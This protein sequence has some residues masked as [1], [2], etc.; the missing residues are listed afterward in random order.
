MIITTA[1]LLHSSGDAAQR[2]IRHD[3]AGEQEQFLIQAAMSVELAG[4]ALLVSL[5]PALVIDAKF[6]DSLLHACGAGEHAKAGAES[7]RRISASEVVNRCIQVDVRLSFLKDDLTLLAALRNSVIHLGTIGERRE[8]KLL[9]T[10][11]KAV[12]MLAAS[13]GENFEN[14]FADYAE[15]AAAH[16]SQSRKQVELEVL[17]RVARGRDE[18]ERRFGTRRGGSL[19]SR[20]AAIK[21]GSPT[22]ARG[23]TGRHR[24]LS[25]SIRLLPAL[26][27]TGNNNHRW[28]GDKATPHQNGFGTAASVVRLP[29]LYSTKSIVGLLAASR[30]TKYRPRAPTAK[31]SE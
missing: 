4:K 27:T 16:V 21:A 19:R 6:F 1:E 28:S 20:T 15:M 5:H 14:M 13:C 25:T 17:A 30:A 12:G 26:S 10:F 11:I 8:A 31:L 7:L 22:S 9:N 2:A 23:P 24:T 18:F 3:L 29:V